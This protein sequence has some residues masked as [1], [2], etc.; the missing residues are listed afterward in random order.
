M[1]APVRSEV[2]DRGD[3]QGIILR[4]YI[5]LPHA[6]YYLLNI[7][8]PGSFKHWLEERLSAGDVTP[9]SAPA[10]QQSRA[11]NL[12]FTAR[13]LNKLGVGTEPLPVQVGDE[14]AL[15]D[16]FGLE[17]REGLVIPHRSRFLGDVGDSAPEGWSWGGTDSAADAH[18]D[19]IDCL[20][21]LYGTAPEQVADT[22]ARLGP[23]GHTAVVVYQRD[24]Y[25][26]ED[27][28]EHFGFKDGISQ[29]TIRFTKRDYETTVRTDRAMHVV[30]AG[31]FILGYENANR[32][33]PLSPAVPT[34]STARSQLL[35]PLKA[36]SAFRRSPLDTLLDFGRNGTY[37]VLRQ[38]HQNV[39]RFRQFLKAN[40]GPEP[41]DQ[42][43][44]A[45]QMVGRWPSGAPLAVWP[46]ADPWSD[47]PDAMRTAAELNSFG[48]DAEDRYGHRCP[49]G[50]HVRRGNPRDSTAHIDGEVHALR[51]VNFHRLLRRGRLYGDRVPVNAEPVS[52]DENRGLMFLCLNADLR[53]QFEFVQ[54]TWITSNKFGGLLDERDPL[55]AHD[56][57]FTMQGAAGHNRACGLQPFVVVRGGAYFFLPGM[58]AL[59]YLAA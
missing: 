10:G 47:S 48:Y 14:H 2:L 30:E 8:A 42:D 17:F 56:G 31:E 37:L 36:P 41:T 50:A 22:W 16:G 25:Q 32:R 6:T 51:R 28:R 12:A 43:R 55:A 54:Q 9:A 40:A 46:D 34:D 33:M 19:R 13:G 4:A 15:Y 49:I 24:V 7:A 3:M 52:D 39:G 23:P 21:L 58:R 38:L 29:P 18:A 45:A 1:A 26:P 27:G 57:C 20:C 5:D 44:L 11:L 35:Q 53:R 59:R